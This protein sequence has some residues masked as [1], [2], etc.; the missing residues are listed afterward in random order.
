MNQELSVRSTRTDKVVEDEHPSEIMVAGKSIANLLNQHEEK[1]NIL[2]DRREWNLEKRVDNLE[3]S[4]RKLEEEV[5][6]RICQ[7]EENPYCP[8]IVER[9]AKIGL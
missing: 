5:F 2:A 1:L 4:L 8:D 3:R 6:F 7:L 9:V